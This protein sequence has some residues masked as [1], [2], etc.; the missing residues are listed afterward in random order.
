MLANT[1]SDSL[2]RSPPLMPIG[3]STVSRRFF[4][5][6]LIGLTSGGS[7]VLSEVARCLARLQRTEIRAVYKRL[8]RN[9]AKTDLAIPYQKCQRIALESLSANHIIAIDPGDL[10]K[11]AARRME[12]LDWVSNGSKKHQATRGFFLLGAVAVD[13]TST[14]KTPRPIALELYTASERTFVSENRLILSLIDTIEAVCRPKAFMPHLVIDRGGDRGVTLTRLVDQ[15]IPFS[16]R[17]NK[18]TLIDEDSK[19]SCPIP[20]VELQRESLPHQGQLERRSSTGK[21]TPLKGRFSFRGVRCRL[22]KKVSSRSLWHVTFWSEDACEPIEILTSIPVRSPQ[23]ALEALARY[24]ARWSVEEFYRF[25]KVG[26]GLEQ[27]R[28]L[29]YWATK[30]LVMAAFLCASHR[31]TVSEIEREICIQKARP[32]RKRT[33]AFHNK[34]YAGRDGHHLWRLQEETAAHSGGHHPRTSCARV[35]H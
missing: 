20:Q 16:I 33:K 28:T 18:R 2:S 35:T 30:Q 29:R 15:A 8:S 21:R 9:L 22:G 31:C 12:G 14:G 1:I 10:C 26:Q 17:L 5:D 19:L 24:L 13:P 32:L 23:Q 4:A 6:L 3:W 11:P 25:S 27:V 34:L 7:L